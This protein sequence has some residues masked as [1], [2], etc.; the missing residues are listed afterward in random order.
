[1]KAP[2]RSEK[3]YIQVSLSTVLGA[4]QLTVDIA[5]AVALL[6]KNL[7]NEV[8]EGAI[9]KAV[10]IEMWI[11]AQ[12]TVPASV[13]VSLVKH[14]EFGTLTVAEHAALNDYT[15]KKNVLYHTQGLIGDQDSNPIPFLRGWF[16]IPKGKQRFGL[17][18]LLRLHI[19]AQGTVDLTVCGFMTYKE[20]T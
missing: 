11:L 13:L 9:V 7:G 10:Y 20:Y 19:F 3:H 17:G 5:S 6:Q 4:A 18:D 12:D 2:I 8:I 15:N 1:M 16:K 14:P